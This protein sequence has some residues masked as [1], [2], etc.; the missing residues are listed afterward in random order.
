MRYT[1]FAALGLLALSLSIFSSPSALSHGGHP[2]NI[3]VNTSVVVQ[4]LGPDPANPGYTKYQYTC[5]YSA[6]A[7]RTASRIVL[8]MT[9][10]YSWLYE[11]SCNNCSW[12]FYQI[13]NYFWIRTGSG[14]CYYSISRAWA[15]AWFPSGSYD[16]D[17]DEATN[18]TCD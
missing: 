8:D 2:E 1:K 15:Q 16:Q 13:S 4:N 12:L 7:D 17:E 9:C 18:V 11:V 14:E 6:V 3:V 5:Y 10:N